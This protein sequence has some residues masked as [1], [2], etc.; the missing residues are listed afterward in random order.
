MT[1]GV[2]ALSDIDASQVTLS[3]SIPKGWLVVDAAGVDEFVTGE[4]RWS[5]D[6]IA[7]EAL[8]RS[9]DLRAPP[10]D[11][12]SQRV[13]SASFAWRL[14]L[15]GAAP[16]T[17][18]VTVVGPTVDVLVAPRVLIDTVTLGQIPVAGEDAR[19]AAIG[20]P[21]VSQPR[22][23]AFRVRFLVVNPDLLTVSWTPRLESAPDGSDAY[24]PVPEKAA[25]DSQ[26]FYAAREWVRV[27][28]PAG[29]APGPTTADAPEGQPSWSG[30]L[31]PG[32]PGPDGTRPAEDGRW[33]GTVQSPDREVLPPGRARS[34]ASERGAN[35]LE[36]LR[37]MGINPMP[38]T[39][40][41]GD[42]WTMLEFS[43]FVAADAPYLAGYRF[44]LTDEGVPFAAAA[45]ASVTIEPEPPLLLSPGQLTGVAADTVASDGG[46]DG[47]LLPPARGGDSAGLARA[48]SSTAAAG[49]MIR[50]QLVAP[51]GFGPLAGATFTSPHTNYTLTTD[52]CA[53]CH[54][55]HVSQGP[56][57]LPSAA[58]R[59]P[60]CFSCHNGSGSNL[61]IQTQYLDPELPANDPTTRSTY[62]HD[63][64]G[65]PTNHSLS[66]VDEFG[67][68]LERHSECADCH[69]S[70][71]STATD[72][73][74]TVTGWTVSG[75]E[76]G[77]S[78]VSVTNGEAATAPAYAFLD[79]TVSAKPTHEYE[80]CFKCHS[81][82]TI[83]PSNAD[84][85]QPASRWYLDKGIEF[86]P[87][88]AAFHPIEA[89]GKNTSTAMANSLSGTSPYKQWNFTTGSTIRC[90]NCHADARA[91]GGQTPAQ[92]GSALESHA[93]TVRGILRQPYRDRVLKSSNETYAAAD[94]AL[95]FQCHAEEPFTNQ[96]SSATNFR[97]HEE[98]VTGLAG[99]G[100]GGTDI[101]TAG[102]GQGNAICAE[103]HFRIHSSAL[104][105]GT[106]GAYPGLINFAPNV[107]PYG[108]TLSWAAR[109]GGGTCTLVCHGKDHDGKSY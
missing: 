27:L 22:F 49:P 5:E 44:Q 84:P 52:A 73:T 59:A 38:E 75:R 70:H 33:G 9:V 79:G 26:P 35:E 43:V 78:G 82:F 77:I 7:G 66:S 51:S 76:A 64:L 34:T 92:P 36:G 37:S 58:P 63:A 93:S 47:D 14:L 106:Q 83:L 71:N 10:L 53:T 98:H 107:Q 24:T 68:R 1:L 103:C 40:L 30:G 72:A 13:V 31:G 109:T 16:D 57:L 41:P 15:P 45:E 56:A 25:S 20:E 12:S 85:P 89:P 86:N 23:E 55:S 104:R 18:P 90:A 95:C 100:N 81:G 48:T 11:A 17:A 94:F 19:Y 32:P 65:V 101:D 99:K 42:A 46:M 74:Q 97:L 39:T 60:L 69:N 87:A 62:S 4:L 21:I 8:T 54:R 50:Y 102:A 2:S 91:F 105:V 88:N 96:S 61:D 80:L 29:L 6:L 108:G 67:G 3:L 28:G